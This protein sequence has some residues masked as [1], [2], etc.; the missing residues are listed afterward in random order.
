MSLRNAVQLICYPNRL[1]NNLADLYTV[2]DRYLGDTIG[3]VHILPL[4]PSN[5]DSGFSPLTH[6][7]VDPAFGTWADVERITAR[8][9]LCLDLTINHIS[10]ESVE[11]KDFLKNGTASAYADLFVQVDRLGPISP[12]D[13]A[14]IHIRKEKEPFR[15]VQFA[16]GERGRVWCTF[17]EQ[18]IDLDYTAAH[19]YQ[20][21]EGYI[22]FLAARGVKLFR[23]DAF[24][25]TTKRIG[26]S[27]FLVEPEVYRILEWFRDTT[28]KYGAET[29][30][31]VHDHT[32]YQYAI[33]RRGMRPYA[34]ALPPLILHC[35]LEGSSRYLRNWLRMCPRNQVTVLDTHDGIC[36]PDVEG[37]L[38]EDQIKA[39]VANVSERS[40]DPIMRRSAVNVHSVGAIYQLTCTFYEALQCDDDAY[41]VARAIQFFTPGIPQVYYVGL[42]AGANDYGLLESSGEARDINRHYYSFEEI[43]QQMQRPVVQRLLELMRFRS[44]YP[45][46]EGR[47]E[48]N[49]SIDSRVLMGWRHGEFYCR[50]DIDLVAKTAVINYRDV[51]GCCERE[52]QC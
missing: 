30:P 11:F 2:I 22:A 35:L 14:L 50:L 18:Q 34:F 20:L 17:T 51:E 9:D 16:N 49:S 19:T 47:F 25:Y 23:L 39:L 4:Y 46:F 26:S 6:A 42:L 21:M 38:P 32:S 10:D 45:A 36:I 52:M 37:V 7:E 8:Y 41:I 3:G 15:E 1:G 12:Q 44:H 5:A 24:G 48:L 40:A 27:C 43:D 33:S 29:L 28:Q 13:L 31:E